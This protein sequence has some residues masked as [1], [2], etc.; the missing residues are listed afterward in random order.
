MPSLVLLMA[1]LAQAAPV[2]VG[3]PAQLERIRKALERPAPIE[4]VRAL[5]SA[6][7]PVFR[8][9][10]KGWKIR[11]PLWQDD[12][13]VPLYVRPT[14][15]PTHFEFQMQVTDEFFRSSVLY[16][17]FT[18]TPFGDVALGIPVVPIVEGLTQATKALRRKLAERAA[19]EEVRQALA[20]LAACRANP[21]GA[22]CS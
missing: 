6:D 7:R 1:M 2:V 12:S 9:T 4:T 13:V 8:L 11:R 10:V 21:A 17:G 16:P 3:D 19:R 5:D 18:H 15:P 20:Q 22:G 14:M